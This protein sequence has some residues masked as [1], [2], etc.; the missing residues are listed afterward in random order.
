MK[1]SREEFCIEF[2]LSEEQFF[3]RELVDSVLSMNLLEYLPE[4][5]SLKN[6][7]SVWLDSLKTL[8]EGCSLKATFLNLDSLKILPED[9]LIDAERVACK[10]ILPTFKG[11]SEFYFGRMWSRKKYFKDY[12]Y[13]RM[14][15]LKFLRS[16]SDLEKALAEY[17]LNQIP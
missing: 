7:G 10:I 14:E 11:S 13:V 8:P 5:C 16:D 1:L 17:Y 4:G 2:E 3:G 6:T 12:V 15:P 9:Y